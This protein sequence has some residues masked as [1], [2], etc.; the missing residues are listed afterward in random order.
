MVTSAYPQDLV[1]VPGN[2]RIPEALGWPLVSWACI[3]IIW[4]SVLFTQPAKP[5]PKE[6]AIAAVAF[7]VALGM[8]FFEFYRRKNRRVL[9]RLPESPAIGI[10]KRGKLKRTVR[11]EEVTLD[12]RY[13]GAALATVIAPASVAFG[14]AVFLLPSNIAISTSERIDAALGVLCFA[15]LA[16]S[17]VKTWWLCE[18]C[19]FP[20]EK[21]KHPERILAPKRDLKLLLSR[22]AE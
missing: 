13:S 3:L 7:I 22:K 10:Y 2:A 8:V 14:L 12:L 17:S 4:C 1:A 9:A 6:Y 21:R 16:A 15:G 5:T 19:L 11:V 18:V 20:H